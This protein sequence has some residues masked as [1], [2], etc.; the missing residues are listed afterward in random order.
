MFEHHPLSARFELR[1]SDEPAALADAALSVERGPSDGGPPRPD[2]RLQGDVDF[3]TW[4]RL[5]AVGNF[6][7]DG[8]TAAETGEVFDPGRPLRLELRLNAE[9]RA[10]A[11]DPMTGPDLAAA[12]LGAA[13]G[14]ALRD[15]SKWDVVAVTQRLGARVRGGFSACEPG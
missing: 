12:L 14:A 1:L 6:R 11:P 3:L 2:V 10:V 15:L 13:P 8:L 7:F 5:A 9:G 4:M